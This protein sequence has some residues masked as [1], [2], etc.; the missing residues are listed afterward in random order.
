M[1]FFTFGGASAAGGEEAKNLHEAVSRL[2]D[3]AR[4]FG[5]MF[6]KIWGLTDDD[7]KRDENFWTRHGAQCEE[8]ARGY[9]YWVWKFYLI[10]KI[11][12]TM[13]EGELLLYLDCGCE[14][15][16]KAKD[17][18][19]Y[20]SQLAHQHKIIGT[21]TNS[22]DLS[23][24]KRDLV[25]AMER[26]TSFRFD[27]DTLKTWH[28]QSGILLMENCEVIRQLFCDA[29]TYMSDCHSADDSPS[30]AQNHPSFREHRHDQSVFNLLVKQRG[31][32]NHLMDPSYFAP[33][34]NYW[35]AEHPI[36]AARNKT[37]KSLIVADEDK[38]PDL[39]WYVQCFGKWQGGLGDFFRSWFCTFVYARIKFD[40][41]NV[42]LYIP[43]HPL[44]ACLKSIENLSP[45]PETFT[46][47]T[48]HY[49]EQEMR[50]S[51]DIL[52]R[53]SKNA[54]L[55]SN[56]RFLEC[57]VLAQH[58]EAFRAEI[59]QQ[60]ILKHVI[61][62]LRLQILANVHANFYCIQLRCGDMFM[63]VSEQSRDTS[64][65]G[66]HCDTEVMGIDPTVIFP[67]VEKAIEF[68]KR[69]FSDAVTTTTD[70]IGN[71]VLITDNV[72][73][74]RQISEKYGLK[75][76]NTQIAHLAVPEKLSPEC[77]L[78]ATLDTAAEFFLLG[79]SRANIMLAYSG[80]VI[81]PSFI[82]EVPIYEWKNEDIMPFDWKFPY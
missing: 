59:V 38:H 33:D 19:K 9:G 40:N 50:H 39:T 72:D 56:I 51:L 31:L 10:G 5:D 7:L 78:S 77:K 76:L 34:W 22:N 71:I 57:D 47:T 46:I 68:L 44:K 6:E 28:M 66:G 80:F 54:I 35:G 74:K 75:T 1:H 17:K 64:S 55:V 48:H 43:E 73:F 8:N 36:W 21:S 70:E 61:S 18:L 13:P 30:V 41:V 25:D 20:F 23:H 42:K 69:E 14:L 2:C 29:Q 79:E 24:T 49:N 11:L 37:G 26:Q 12:A 15:N 4:S 52:Q 58:R 67:A 63:S 62:R 60:D 82:Y 27:V 45:I 3:Q 53:Q 16:V 81:W 32:H 65:H